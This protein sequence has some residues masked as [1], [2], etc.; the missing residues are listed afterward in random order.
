MNKINVRMLEFRTA[1]RASSGA[2]L[3]VEVDGHG[4]ALPEG[5]V[6]DVCHLDVSEGQSLL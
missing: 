2:T 6:A 1:R 4:E 5:R 3:L